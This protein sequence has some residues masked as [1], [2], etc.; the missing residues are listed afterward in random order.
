MKHTLEWH[1]QRVAD[2]RLHLKK[3]QDE[4]QFLKDDISSHSYLIHDQE[5]GG[6][7][8]FDAEFF[9]VSA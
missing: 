9:G 1:K 3:L 7:D 5:T 4:V 8:G 6:S 2:K